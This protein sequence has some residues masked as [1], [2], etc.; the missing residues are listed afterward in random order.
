MHRTTNRS[1][2]VARRGFTLV[3]A[4]VIIVIL[5]IIAAVIAP[6]FFGR[7]SDAKSGVA[8]SNA[9][10]LV[11]AANLLL[12]DHG[13]SDDMGIE[14]L[15]EPPSGVDEDEYKGP[16]VQNRQELVDP[17]GNDYVLIYPAE[18]NTDF[19]IVSYGADGVPGGEGE[20][21]DIIKP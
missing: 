14:A 13:I 10:S 17:W 20:N 18:K 9:A 4:I 6:R 3:E 21:E 12:V 8:A 2:R 19:D 16:Y 15:F 5:G 7:I 1:R 11:Q